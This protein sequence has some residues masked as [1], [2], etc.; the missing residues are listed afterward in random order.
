M[1]HVS[2]QEIKF[3]ERELSVSIF[4]HETCQPLRCS[5]HVLILDQNREVIYQGS[6]V[7][8]LE[9]WKFKAG[10]FFRA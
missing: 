2:F 3:T 8:L 10:S 1:R 6:G 5:P 7:I 4:S 9:G